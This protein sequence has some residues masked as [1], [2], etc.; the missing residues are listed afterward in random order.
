[1]IF[2]R[3]PLDFLA[4]T[5]RRTGLWVPM[6]LRFGWWPCGCCGC[7]LTCQHCIGDAPCAFEVVIADVAEDG[8]GSCASLDGTYILDEFFSGA[9]PSTLCAWRYTFPERICDVSFIQLN[10]Y[11]TTRQ[12]WVFFWDAVRADWALFFKV[13]GSK[14]DCMNLANEPLSFTHQPL[15][16]Q[17]DISAG[18]TC[19]V[20]TV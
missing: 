20:S 2:P 7:T 11:G 18:A 1:M 12:L 15:G 4:Y 3:D 10:V 13:Y 14:V 19:L 8:C 16:W 5:A 6:P 9:D 17:C